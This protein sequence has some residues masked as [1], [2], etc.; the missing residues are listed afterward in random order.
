[1]SFSWENARQNTPSAG[2]FLIEVSVFPFFP[3]Q[4]LSINYAQ[5][6]TAFAF[7]QYFKFFL[8]VASEPVFPIFNYH[9]NKLP[10]G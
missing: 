3:Y 2:L 6:I 9:I 5:P 10:L 1:V 8:V 4:C 7:T